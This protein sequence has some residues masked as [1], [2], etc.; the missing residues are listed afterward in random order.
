MSDNYLEV[1]DN[2]DKSL[3]FEVDQD[4]LSIRVCLFYEW[5][6]SVDVKIDFSLHDVKHLMQ[7]AKLRDFIDQALPLEMRLN[8]GETDEP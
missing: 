4:K 6:D 3:E 2:G 5:R 7:M 1:F 8:N